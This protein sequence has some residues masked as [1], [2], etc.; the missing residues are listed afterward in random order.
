MCVLLS[1]T[2]NSSHLCLR[3]VLMNSLRLSPLCW[4]ERPAVSL[5][6]WKIFSVFADGRRW[7]QKHSLS[8]TVTQLTLSTLFQASDL[9]H[10]LTINPNPFYGLEHPDM[11]C[12]L[13]F[14]KSVS[15]HCCVII[16]RTLTPFMH[17]RTPGRTGLWAEAKAEQ[18]L[19]EMRE[20]H[21]EVQIHK[22]NNLVSI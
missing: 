7:N 22:S 15:E 1:T 3:T 9:S 4:L 2:A 16:S 17:D 8:L 12:F 6:C 20:K 14:L 11:K 21:L 13:L 19:K 5:A 18:K 10:L